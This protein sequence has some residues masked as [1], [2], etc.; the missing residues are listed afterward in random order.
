MKYICSIN[1]KLVKYLHPKTGKIAPGG[2]FQAFNDNWVSSKLTAKEIAEEVKQKHGL[3]AW[4]LVEGKRKKESTQL[5]QAGLIIIDI[6]NQDDG[7]DEDGNK[8][9]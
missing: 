7:K 1:T 3:C 6:D 9:Q 2:N 8:I 5:I 4:H